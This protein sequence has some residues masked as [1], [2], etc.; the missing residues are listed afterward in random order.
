MPPGL[1]SIELYQNG[2]ASVVGVMLL[3][4]GNAKTLGGSIRRLENLPNDSRGENLH[5]FAAD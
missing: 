3:L 4:V 1:T 2:L 5:A